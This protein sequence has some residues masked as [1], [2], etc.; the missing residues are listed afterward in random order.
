LGPPQFSS[1]APFRS[2]D[3]SDPSIKESFLEDFIV[4]NRE[5]IH[6]FRSLNITFSGVCCCNVSKVELND[7]RKVLSTYKHSYRFNWLCDN[8]ARIFARYGRNLYEFS[9]SDISKVDGKDAEKNSSSSASSQV[10]CE[11][12]RRFSG[13]DNYDE[14][15]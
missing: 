1:R 10:I 12:R 15:E 8:N 14:W 2:G 5:E 13:G 7:I 9:S 4:I 3:A 11:S 6:K